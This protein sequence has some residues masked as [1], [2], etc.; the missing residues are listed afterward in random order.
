MEDEI[1]I[2]KL[3]DKL[4]I[5]QQEINELTSMIHACLEGIRSDSLGAGEIVDTIAMLYK[6]MQT[7]A[8]KLECIRK[9][10]R[11]EDSSM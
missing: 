3:Q 5:Y 11:S 9:S 2:F 7:M 4:E 6:L 1:Q 8:Q 10:I